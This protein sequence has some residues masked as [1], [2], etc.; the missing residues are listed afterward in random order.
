MFYF[1]I[2]FISRNKQKK[3]QHL[4]WRTRWQSRYFVSTLEYVQLLLY[5]QANVQSIKTVHLLWKPQFPA[6]LVYFQRHQTENANSIVDGLHVPYITE[7]N[8]KK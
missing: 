7:V 1:K 4:P 8:P 2:Y 6:N 5:L 3:K